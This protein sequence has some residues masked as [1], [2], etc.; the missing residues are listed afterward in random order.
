M[1]NTRLYSVRYEDTTRTIA[2]CS[3]VVEAC[4]KHKTTTERE[5]KTLLGLENGG[6]V[7]LF[8]DSGLFLFWKVHTKLTKK[9]KCS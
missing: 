9:W 6:V 5:K 4:F 3:A 1:S 7:E 8:S 2:L